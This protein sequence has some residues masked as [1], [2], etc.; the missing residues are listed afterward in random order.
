MQ[1]KLAAKA[2]EMSKKLAAKDRIISA[3][4]GRNKHLLSAIQAA[5][6]EV[7]NL[8]MENER[9]AGKLKRMKEDRAEE[10]G[11]YVSPDDYDGM[12]GYDGQL[13]SVSDDEDDEIL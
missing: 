6:T 4:T 1:K 12:D 8:A 13:A 7:S 9:L 5:Y 11:G 10:E 2:A 3:V